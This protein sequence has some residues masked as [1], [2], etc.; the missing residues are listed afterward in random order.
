M[1]M[2][3][4]KIYHLNCRQRHSDWAPDGSLWLMVVLTLAHNILS[5]NAHDHKY[6]CSNPLHQHTHTVIGKDGT[7]W[8]IGC[9]CFAF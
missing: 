4:L 3:N 2:M 1:E 9:T 6:S 5:H 7:K 8:G